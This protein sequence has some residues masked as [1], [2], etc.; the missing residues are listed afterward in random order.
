LKNFRITRDELQH[1]IQ[2]FINEMEQP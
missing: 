2:Q 1:R